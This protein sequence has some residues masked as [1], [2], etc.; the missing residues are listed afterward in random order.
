MKRR[1]LLPLAALL[2]AALTACGPAGPE[3]TPT[4]TP[5]AA[6]LPTPSPTPEPV[7]VP[8]VL[9]SQRFSQ[10]FTA[11]DGTELLSAAYTLPDFENRE[12]SAALT[13]I[14]AWY[15]ALGEDML[16][17]AAFTAQD[18]SADYELSG[19]QDIPFLPGSEE[20][21][22]QCTYQNERVISFSRTFYATIAGTAH[23]TVLRLG[24]LFD[25]VTGEELT[26]TQCFT[27]AIAASEQALRS[28]LSSETVAGLTA[29]GMES[30]R[31]QA[32]FQPERFYLTEEGFVF[33]FQADDLGISGSPIEVTVPYS[34]L[35]EYLVSW[36]G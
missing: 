12:A 16:S 36:I 23:P 4:P 5:T 17:T 14:S 24:D 27:D 33:W 2:A 20:M 21:D 18:A 10:T 26:F 1:I 3:P 8:P 22:F 15:A 25:L 32:A 11:E 31:I 13:A 28:V 30:A 7:Y 9:S 29:Q 19:A 6:P 35:K 34:A